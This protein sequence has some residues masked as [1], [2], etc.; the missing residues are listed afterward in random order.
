MI[1]ATC[2]NGF[3]T[4]WLSRAVGPS[5]AVIAVDIQVL[6]YQSKLAFMEATFM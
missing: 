2:G 4:L 6:L 1:D 3:D 5:G